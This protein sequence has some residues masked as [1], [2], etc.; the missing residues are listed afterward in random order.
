MLANPD[1]MLTQEVARSSSAP[2]VLDLLRRDDLLDSDIDAVVDTSLAN[3]GER[4]YV[5]QSLYRVDFDE[6]TDSMRRSAK[7]SALWS[8]GDAR[9]ALTCALLLHRPQI[10]TPC[11]AD[12]R[13]QDTDEMGAMPPFGHVPAKMQARAIRRARQGRPDPAHPLE[14]P[15]VWEVGHDAVLVEATA[16]GVNDNAPRAGLRTPDEV[17]AIGPPNL[18]GGAR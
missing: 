3:P 17:L 7:L 1:L 9:L 10:L 5:L 8:A 13:P 2:T 12:A 14:G 15:S 4:F 6:I 16:A 18:P 11:G